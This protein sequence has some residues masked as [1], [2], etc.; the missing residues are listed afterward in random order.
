MGMDDRNVLKTQG[1]FEGKG[2]PVSPKNA[3]KDTINT[4]PRE[5]L[6]STDLINFLEITEYKNC[7]TSFVIAL[8]DVLVLEAIKLI[9][10]NQ[11]FF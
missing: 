9:N 2:L 8:L 10:C 6:I 5:K 1:I 3:L 11:Y 4:N 7:L